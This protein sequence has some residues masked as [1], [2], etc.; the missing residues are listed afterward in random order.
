MK[1]E[2][3]I[4]RSLL[5]CG[6]FVLESRGDY[7]LQKWHHGAQLRAELLDG[8]LLLALAR[9]EEIGAALF[10][11]CDPGFRETPVANL[12]EDFAH[13]FPRLPGDN[14]RSGGIIALLGSIADGVAHV[15]EAAAVNQVDDELEFVEAFEIGDLGL[16]ACVREGL[17]ARF[18]H[19]P[20]AAA[21]YRLLAKEL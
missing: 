4:R 7:R 13:F 6:R 16:R 10:I 1:V 14:A 20:P 17:E 18:D 12:R 11:F 5:R 2:R 3:K 15:A 9:C 8:V 21:A 19:C